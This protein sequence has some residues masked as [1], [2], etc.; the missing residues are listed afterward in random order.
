MDY[1][2][3]IWK[4][5]QDFP[6]YTASNFGK[7]K[8]I[9]FNK[10]KILKYFKIY[11]VKKLF[12][13]E[14]MKWKPP[15]DT[16]KVMVSVILDRSGSM[17]GM[18]SD[19]VGGVNSFI[20]Q[21]R[22]ENGDTFIQMVRF[23][24]DAIE[25]FIEMQ[26]LDSI[27]LLTKDDYIPRGCTPL[28]DAIGETIAKLEKEW[29]RLQP[30]KALVVICT[31]GAE[32]ASKEYTRDKIKQMITSRIDS[33]KWS[34]IYLGAN[35]D[36]FAEGGGIGIPYSNIANYTYTSAGYAKNWSTAIPWTLRNLKASGNVMACNLGGDID[37]FGQINRK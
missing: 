5:I 24:S 6:D 32:N 30:D 25:T 13:G 20:E 31:D 26:R 8:S 23:D 10:E 36:S 15:K 29:K 14:S 21:Q 7:I 12:K 1:V 3:E 4:T 19:V 11:D 27:P 28:L 22:K 2:I 17:A 37:E 18:E 34:F 9:K 35:L 33:D 16:N